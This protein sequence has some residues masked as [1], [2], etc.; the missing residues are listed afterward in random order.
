M[1]PSES[2]FRRYTSVRFLRI[3][4]RRLTFPGFRP[5]KRGCRVNAKAMQ[6]PS[7]GA[8]SLAVPYNPAAKCPL[9][10]DTLLWPALGADSG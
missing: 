4:L 6:T 5:R 1:R 2:P 3:C 7:E 8:I 10:L 9:F